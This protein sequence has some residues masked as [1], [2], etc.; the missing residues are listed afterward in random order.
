MIPY[1]RQDIGE[2]DIAAVTAVLRSDWLTQGPT[3]ERFERAMADYCGAKYAVA[4]SN[5]TAALHLACLA[6]DLKP[7]DTLWTS[8][9]TFVA[10]ANCARYCGADVDFIDIDARTYNMDAAALE[11]KLKRASDEKKLPAAIVPVHFSGQPCAMAEIGALT[12]RYGVKVIEDAS[13]AV[14]ADY[15]NTKIGACEHSDMAVFSFHAVKIMTTGEGGMIMTNDDELY[16]R[17]ALLRS[18]GITRDTA[19]MTA[20]PGGGWYYQQI[21]LGFNYRL[22]DIQAALGLAQLGRIETFLAR[23]RELAQRYDELLTGLPL[24]TPWQHPDGRSS[25]HLYV[26]K[27]DPRREVYDELRRA[28]IGVQVHYIPVHLQPYYRRLGFELGQFPEA[29]RYYRAA[30]SLPIHNRLTD[31]DQDTVIDALRKAL[32]RSHSKG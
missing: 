18:H 28:G 6:L 4:V 27:L 29:E 13:H 5:G 12:K 3:I 9:N 31:A 10:S 2:D 16:R 22:T 14:G 8:P 19:Q 23:R 11:A 21:E 32:D 30:L 7:G 24:T 15:R 20:E 17:L 25:Y 1:G 26:V